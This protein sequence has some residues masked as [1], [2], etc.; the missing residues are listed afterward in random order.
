[1][2]LHVVVVAVV[3]IFSVNSGIPESGKYLKNAFNLFHFL[4]NHSKETT[5]GE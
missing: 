4:R 5:K 3:V 2:H 1:M